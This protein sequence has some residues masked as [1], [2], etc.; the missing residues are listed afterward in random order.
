MTMSKGLFHK[1]C[2][3]PLTYIEEDSVCRY[4]GENA[5]RAEQAITQKE[6]AQPVH[7]R[8]NEEA[9]LSKMKERV[10][11]GWKDGREVAWARSYT[12]YRLW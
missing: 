9:S 3:P 2:G 6:G 5:V 1:I 11:G 10:E 8:S 4:L 7:S 12:A